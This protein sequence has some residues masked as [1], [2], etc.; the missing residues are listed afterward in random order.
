MSDSDFLRVAKHFENSLDEAAWHRELIERMK[1][2]V[3]GIRP[4]VISREL[5]DP[6]DELRRFRHLYRNLYESKLKPRRV[7]EVSESVVPL[8]RAFRPCHERFTAWIDE[9]I[10][11]EE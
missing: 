5:E 4:A 3:P 11:R 10:D 6:L 9:L 2:D 7:S 1:I 8:M